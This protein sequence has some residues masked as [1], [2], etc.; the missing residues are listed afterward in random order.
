MQ[1]LANMYQVDHKALKVVMALGFFGVRT[2]IRHPS[3]TELVK[4]YPHVQWMLLHEDVRASTLPSLREVVDNLV[5]YQNVQFDLGPEAFLHPVYRDDPAYYAH[6]ANRATRVI[7][8]RMSC[9]VTL[10][11]IERITPEGLSWLRGLVPYLMSDIQPSIHAYRELVWEHEGFPSTAKMFRAVK[12]AIGGR[13][14]WN[15]ETGY[16]TAP[17]G[18]FKFWPWLAELDG[19]RLTEAQAGIHLIRDLELHQ[20]NGCQGY[21]VY[22]TYSGPGKGA[23]DNFGLLDQGLEPKFRARMVAEWLEEKEN[24]NAQEEAPRA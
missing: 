14:W 21:V 18:T 7:L 2:N 12:K 1:V 13:P 20:Q 22:Q 5:D 24:L 23:E 15:T 17:W 9:P 8:D 6:L 10:N 11:T 3:I 19:K 16:H 4:N